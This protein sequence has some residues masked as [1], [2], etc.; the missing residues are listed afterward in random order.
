MSVVLNVAPRPARA[1]ETSVKGDYLQA[2]RLIERLHRLLLDVIKDEFDRLG[3]TELNSVQALLIYNI[4]DAELSAGELKKR[5]YYLGS[6]VSYNI[7]KLTEMGYIHHKRSETDRR[8]VRISLAPKGRDAFEVVNKLYHRQL[9]SVE[10][11]GEVNPDDFR[12]LNRSLLK[13]ERF[14]SDQI[15]FRT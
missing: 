14:W 7:K 15:R 10:V 11:V 8:E 9:G 12:S 5:G 1:E 2:L 3:K 4:G 13:L 6:N